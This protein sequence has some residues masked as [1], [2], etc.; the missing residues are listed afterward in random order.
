MSEGGGEQ[1]RGGGVQEQGR[2]GNMDP[3]RLNGPPRR[4]PSSSGC[5]RSG[6]EG[7]ENNR[8]DM[9]NWRQSQAGNT[10]R[11]MG[12]RGLNSFSSFLPTES[13]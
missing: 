8:G 4:W 10:Q 9:C 2:R 1:S 7:T 11:V 6:A 13:L 12:L 5:G 3:R